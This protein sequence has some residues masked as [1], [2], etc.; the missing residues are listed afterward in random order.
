MDRLAAPHADRPAGPGLAEALAGIARHLPDLRAEAGPPGP[1]AFTPAMLAGADPLAL[2]SLLDAEARIHPGLD[3]KAQAAFAISRAARSLAHALAGLLV[4]RGEVPRLT[5]DTVAFR[6]EL[7][8]WEHGGKAGQS[9]RHIVRIAPGQ[10]LLAGTPAALQEAFHDALVAAMSPVVAAL[11]RAA[12]LSPGALWRLVADMV[13]LSFLNVGEQAGDV[14]HAQAAA[15]AITRRPGSRLHN[16]VSGFQRITLP[17][18]ADPDRI[19]AERWFITRGGCCR[20]YTHPEGETCAVCVLLTP[21][22]QQARLREHLRRAH[23]AT[24]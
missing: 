11:H 14:L 7:Y 17:D 24:A 12:G 9:V 22:R 15:L 21:E 19:L 3:R 20:W 1:G 4:L 13:C 10:P 23:E 8:S 2:Q 16:P 5:P 6:A 18:P